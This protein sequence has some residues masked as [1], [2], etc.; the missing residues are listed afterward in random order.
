MVLKRT[1]NLNNLNNNETNYDYEN[2][3]QPTLRRIDKLTNY[4]VGTLGVHKKWKGWLTGIV[5]VHNE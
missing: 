3:E 1:F 4:I 5:S 2:N